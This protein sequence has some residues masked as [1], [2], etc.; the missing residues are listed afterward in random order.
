MLCLLLPILAG[1][2]AIQFFE[3][4]TE[5]TRVGDADL[6][7]DLSDLFVLGAEQGGGGMQPEETQILYGAAAQAIFAAPLQLA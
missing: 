6:L 4:A 7:G 3:A 5:I 1:T 2:D